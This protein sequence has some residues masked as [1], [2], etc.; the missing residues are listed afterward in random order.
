M[1]DELE[2]IWKEAAEWPIRVVNPE[3]S[4]STLDQM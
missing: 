1:F 4:L 2:K 3:F